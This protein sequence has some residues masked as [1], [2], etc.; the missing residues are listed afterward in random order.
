LF[1]PH[2]VDV[3]SGVENNQGRKEE[4]KIREFVLAAKLAIG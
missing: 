1:R 3:A 4:T 2:A